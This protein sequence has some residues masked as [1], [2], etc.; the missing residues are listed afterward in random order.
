MLAPLI[1]EFIR[2]VDGTYDVLRDAML[3]RGL[4]LL[5]RG[6]ELV[7]RLELVLARLPERDQ[8]RVASA[9]VR[10]L[11]VKNPALQALITEALDA[12]DGSGVLDAER[13]KLFKAWHTASG[14]D[15]RVVWAAWMMLRGSPAIALRTTRAIHLGEVE[16]QVGSVADAFGR[17][18][19]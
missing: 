19:A 4:D 15:R 7:E 18:L 3:E 17:D 16:A 14:M 8:I 2:D 5:P 12:A 1:V 6:D 13:S 10:R 9:S 11:E